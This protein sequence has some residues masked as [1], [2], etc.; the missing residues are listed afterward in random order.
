LAGT[1]LQEQMLAYRARER[2]SQTELARR[3]GVT[4]QTI[5]SIENGK[6][7]PSKTT[8]IRIMDVVGQQKEQE[9]EHAEN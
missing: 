8:L 4:L 6:Q 1:T 9:V 7:N 2:I 3:C 5:N